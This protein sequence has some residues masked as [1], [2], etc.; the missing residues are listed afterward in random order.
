M[1]REVPLDVFLAREG[2]AYR[3]TGIELP[4]DVVYERADLVPVIQARE[5][6]VRL[7]AYEIFVERRQ[8]AG[9]GDGGAGAEAADAISDWLAAERELLEQDETS[10][11]R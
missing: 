5:E 11:P 6:R 8:A 2:I 9:T 1:D 10:E 3:D 4:D 7:R